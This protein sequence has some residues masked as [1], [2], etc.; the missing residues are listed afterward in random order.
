MRLPAATRSSTTVVW[1]VLSVITV[2]SWRLG[3]AHHAGPP[4][5][6]VAITV[7]VLA[8]GFVKARLIIRYFMEVQTAPAWLRAAT[9]G[10]LVA[11]WGGVLAIYLF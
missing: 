2:V 3:P 9:D 4:A 1:V 7:I 8:L 6:S 10:W 5:P 11:L